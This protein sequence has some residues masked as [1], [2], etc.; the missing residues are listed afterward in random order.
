MRSSNKPERKLCCSLSA[1][2]SVSVPAA[3]SFEWIS[4]QSV[5]QPLE[6]VL[7]RPRW[8]G[9]LDNKEPR[10]SRVNAV[11]NPSS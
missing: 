11:T 8:P 10:N 2:D 7:E 1:L 9:V 3:M 6:S 4:Q 5:L